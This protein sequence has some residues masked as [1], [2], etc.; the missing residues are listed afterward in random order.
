MWP[1][2]RR[3]PNPDPRVV[4]FAR[5]CGIPEPSTDDA[6]PLLLEW[7]FAPTEEIPIFLARTAQLWRHEKLPET[8]WAISLENGI[9]LHDQTVY[10]IKAAVTKLAEREG[11]AL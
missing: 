8:D 7:R 10:R 9:L 6:I 1:F 2:K 11:I 4:A 5:F 3:P